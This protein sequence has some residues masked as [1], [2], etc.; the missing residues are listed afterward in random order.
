MV[1]KKQTKTEK[2]IEDVLVGTVESVARA[3]A[4]FFESLAADGRKFLSNQATKAKR[5]EHGVRAWR[6]EN[7]PEIPDL[8][9]EVPGELQ[10]DTTEARH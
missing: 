2:V 8:A 10:D 9:G 5:L 3:G 7:A 6:E 1:D 4:R